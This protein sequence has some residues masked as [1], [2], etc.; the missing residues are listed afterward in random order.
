MHGFHSWSFHRG[1]LD[2]G[3]VNLRGEEDRYGTD[4]VT[5]WRQAGDY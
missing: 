3:G 5:F 2:L 1:V 4:P